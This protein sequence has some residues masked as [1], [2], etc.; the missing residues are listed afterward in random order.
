MKQSIL[1]LWTIPR[2]IVLHEKF[3]NLE[4][5]EKFTPRVKFKAPDTL[6]LHYKGRSDDEAS[7]AS[8]FH[9][10]SKD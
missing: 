3:L 9:R 8:P 2:G 7:K 4:D 10:F 6:T 1:F 5:V